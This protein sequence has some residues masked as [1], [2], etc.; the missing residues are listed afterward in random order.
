[1]C[2][3]AECLSML[4][5]ERGKLFGSDVSRFVIRSI[6]ALKA[7]LAAALGIEAWHL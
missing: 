7:K 1:M 2:P 4:D 5:F 3:W 6:R